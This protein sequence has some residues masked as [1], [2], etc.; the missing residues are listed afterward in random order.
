MTTAGALHLS[1]AHYQSLVAGSCIPEDIVRQRGYRTVTDP[2]ELQ[3][4]GF[5]RNQS[6]TPALLIPIHSPFGEIVSHQIRPDTP[7]VLEGKPLKYESPPGG[8]PRIDVPPSVRRSLSDPTQDLWITEGSK[9]ADAAA[10]V[11]ICCVALTGV[12][13]FKGRNAAG[14]SEVL[15]DLDHLHLKGRRVVLCFDSDVTQKPLVRAAMERL[16]GIL[17]SRGASVAVCHLS[18]SG[19]S[20]VGL[21]DAI[22][23]GATS[24]DLRSW[25]TD[26]DAEGAKSSADKKESPYVQLVRLAKEAGLVVWKDRQGEACATIP[27]SGRPLHVRCD[28]ERLRAFL[29]TVYEDKVG[30]PPM[31][32]TLRGATEMIS[33]TGG[34]RGDVHDCA[35]RVWGTKSE[36]FLF[37]AGEDRHVVRV[38][39]DGWNLLAPG[40]PCPVRFFSNPSVR[41]LPVPSRGGE[42]ED[43]RKVLNVTDDGFEFV[44]AWLLGCFLH[45]GGMP[46]LLATG[47]QGSGKS[48]G[49]R[50]IRSVIDPN[51]TPLRNPPKD[52]RTLG[53]AIRGSYVLAYDNLSTVRG[54]VSDW[55]CSIATG[56]GIQGYKLYREAQ[57]Y[58]IKARCPILL[59]GIG[60]IAS[61]PDLLDRSL[62]IRFLRIDG[63]GR[64]RS[65]EE[66]DE[67]FNAALPGILGALLDRVSAGLRSLPTLSI[68]RELPRLADLAR[69]VTACEPGP[70][71]GR[72][73]DL[74]AAERRDQHSGLVESDVTMRAL[75]A[76][77]RE[78]RV[79]EGSL[80][81]VLEALSRKA[82]DSERRS[83]E[84]PKTPRGLRAKLDRFAPVLRNLRIGFEDLPRKGDGRRVR[85]VLELPNARDGSTDRISAANL[86]SSPSPGDVSNQQMPIADVHD[87]S[88]DPMSVSVG[89][90]EGEEVF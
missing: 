59:N 65:E 15:G 51:E 64:R 57:E 38:T 74:I 79:V 80:A 14:G 53:A 86:K 77:V 7:R 70:E 55:L 20:K 23:S 3:V 58:T 35:L 17:K 31:P 34:M 4:L 12:W 68:D 41:A 82:T 78:E 85:L 63:T 76:L 50:Y 60:D 87:G 61:R 28:D 9:K 52:E 49:C 11:G 13:G 21:D 16:A 48:C 62:P 10:G 90:S 43:L 18:S 73:L 22:V 72:F 67:Q 37:L 29:F 47:E 24:E 81:Q 46:L 84:W 36:R 5:T 6:K 44:K 42:L 39:P 26:F 66:L 54:E 71:R 30:S 32:E 75:V 69:W 27:V 33:I 56:G 88:D 83:S 1:P 40:E 89:A 25:T 45:T 8:P 19:S 2:E